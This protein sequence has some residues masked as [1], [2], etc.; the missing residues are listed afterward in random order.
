MKL[1]AERAETMA[2]EAI[3]AEAL[4]SAKN[5]CLTCSF[6]VEDMV[7]LHLARKHKPDIPVLFLDTGYHFPET[8]AYRD[9]M[10]KA[11]SLNLINLTPAL[12]VE[13]QEAEYGKL[14]QTDP[15]RCCRI[16]KVEPLLR[17]LA[18]Y[19]AWLTGLR[20]EQ[21]PSRKNLKK[22]EAHV[23]PSGKTIVKVNPIADWNWKGVW[24]YIE[25]NEIPY[26]SLYD[27]GYR[28]IGCAPCTSL[29][30]DPSDPRSGR[31]GGKKLECGIH[32][33]DREA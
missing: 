15:D 32:T 13:A 3:I 7:V 12:S 26:L 14:Y 1:T 19:D 25:V 4:A 30:I 8:Y 5:P 6:Q 9:R 33:F 27:Q 23:L 2:A 17:A 31:W 10:A 20:R 28:S 21:S 16:R 24:A 18:G 29:P 22:I 11:W